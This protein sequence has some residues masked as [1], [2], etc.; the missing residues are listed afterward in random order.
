MIDRRSFAAA[1]MLAPALGGF[2]AFAAESEVQE[3]AVYRNDSPIGRH[4]LRFSREGQRLAVE[5]DIELEVKLAFITLYRYRHSNRELWEQGRLLSFTSR[6][7][8]NGTRHEVEARRTG[9]VILV[10]GSQGTIEA[11][12]DALPTTYW[13]RRF[14]DAPVWIDTQEGGLKRCMVTPSGTVQVAAAGNK[15]GA[16]GF[17]ISGDLSLDLWYAGPQWVKL[18]FKGSD[19]SVIDYRLERAVPD[20]VALAG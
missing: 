7:D 4:S 12:G 16:D 9:E 2:R 11:P 5:I 17:A 18:E 15:V 8:D 13:H 3:F 1:A 14:L 10:R 20:L 19:G 6:T